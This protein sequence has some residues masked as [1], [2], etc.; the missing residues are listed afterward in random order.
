MRRGREADTNEIGDRFGNEKGRE[1]IGEGL[2][3]QQSIQLSL[4]G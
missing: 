4:S 1:D 2:R 3:I